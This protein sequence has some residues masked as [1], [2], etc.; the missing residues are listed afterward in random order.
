[1]WMSARKRNNAVLIKNMTIRTT[2]QPAIR[3]P[4]S[5]EASANPPVIRPGLLSSNSRN[6]IKKNMTMT[7]ATSS[8]NCAPP[9]TTRSS[10]RTVCLRFPLADL[11]P[12]TLGRSEYDPQTRLRRPYLGGALDSLRGA[13]LRTYAV[14]FNSRD[15]R[16]LVVIETTALRSEWDYSR[17]RISLDGTSD[18]RAGTRRLD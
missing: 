18:P 5:R 10:V 13:G 3:A 16:D 6:T 11:P 7:F 17:R 2:S 15:G 14:S 12:H 1:M 4:A 9:C 8:F